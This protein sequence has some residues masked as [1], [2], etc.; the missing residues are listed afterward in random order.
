MIQA[1]YTAENNLGKLSPD[2]QQK[3]RE[4]VVK[5]L[6]EAYF[7]WVH[8]TMPHVL[9]NSKTYR[10]MQYSVNQEKY[11]KVFLEDGNVPIDNNAEKQYVH[12]ASVRRIG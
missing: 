3:E 12:S 6:V 7:A 8:K 1:I 11:L 5:P 9:T 10:G 2:E 4:L